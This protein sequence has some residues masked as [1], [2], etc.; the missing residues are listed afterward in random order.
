MQ[1]QAPTLPRVLAMVGFAFS[2]FGLLLFLWLSFGGPVPLKSKG[3]RFEIP[4]REAPQLAIQADVRISGVTVGKV[5]EKRAELGSNQTLAVVELERK[6]APIPRDARA[7]VR[8]KTI[9]GQTYIELTGGHDSAG[10]VPE[11][12][13]LPNRQVG[14]SVELDE[15]LDSL[16]PFTRRAFRTWQQSLAS[17]VDGRGRD[18]ND[19]FGNL[20]SFVES[21][22]DLMQVLYDQRAALKA[23]VRNTGEVFSAVTE[24]ED[25]LDKLVRSSDRVFGAIASQRES[26]A[27]VWRIF[28][29]F[30]DESKLTFNRLRTFADDA[31]PLFHDLA[32]A[33]ADL[34]P[35]LRASGDLGP[36]L[37]R[38]FRNLDPLIASSRRSLPALRDVFN[39]LR[40]LLGSLGPFLQQLNPLVDWLAVSQMTFTDMLAHLGISSAAV[41]KTGDPNAVGHYLRQIGPVGTE[42]VAMWPERLSSNRGNTY[43]NPG[44]LIGADVARSGVWPSFDCRNAGGEVR[45]KPPVAAGAGSSAACRVQKPFAFEGLQLR[46]P[47]I[48]SADYSRR[49]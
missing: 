16:D 29:S 10:M 33:A 6:F 32:P 26:F 23:L 18:L 47:H 5:R 31:R 43:L 39:G 30:L 21:G 19:A 41:G 22:G 1:K 44:V 12:G 14:D 48:E 8:Q 25:Q 49:R 45:A 2:C 17:A 46:Y 28:P 15:I 34:G 3:Y 37:R 7:Y 24:R 40:P 38:L 9:L 35:A 36:D 42:T 13:R 4:I 11:G 27:E 20:P